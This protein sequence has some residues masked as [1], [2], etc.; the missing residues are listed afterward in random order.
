[1]VTISDT[2]HLK[3]VHRHISSEKSI[4]FIVISNDFNFALFYP[5]TAQ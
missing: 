1:M 4:V 5:T 3:S 2:M